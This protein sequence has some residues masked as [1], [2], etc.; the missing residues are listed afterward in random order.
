MKDERNVSIFST[1]DW[2]QFHENRQYS[3]TF[4][5]AILF[6]HGFSSWK[7]LFIYLEKEREREREREFVSEIEVHA[8]DFC[9]IS[10]PRE[11]RRRQTISINR[12]NFNIIRQF[13]PDLS[14]SSSVWK[15]FPYLAWRFVD[16]T[17]RRESLRGIKPENPGDLV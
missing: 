7:Y 1:P 15:R 14:R 4:Y 6:V 13:L 3:A 9:R 5:F 17:R 10:L 16:T 12:T 8:R 11:I 2:I